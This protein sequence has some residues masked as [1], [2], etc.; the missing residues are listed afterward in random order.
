MATIVLNIPDKLELN[1]S[2]TVKFIAAKLY[3]AGKLTLGQAAEIAGLSKVTFAEILNDYNVSLINYPV[4][5]I[6]RDATRI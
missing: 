5:D 4:E 6:K 3:E 2:D 1:P